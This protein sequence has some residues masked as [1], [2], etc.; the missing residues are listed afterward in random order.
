[1][2]RTAVVRGLGSWLPP[3]LVTNH[4]LAQ[5]LDTSDDWIRS[6]TGIGARHVITPGVATSDLAVQAG[7]RAL[8]SAAIKGVDAVVLATTTPDYLCPATAPLVSARLGLGNVPAFDVA[9]VCTGFLYA[10]ATAAGLI[11]S[12]VAD[13]VL[14][15]GADT[16][17][18]VLDPQDRSTRAIFG[19]GAGAV[20]LA[21][22]TADEIGALGPVRLASDGA[23]AKLIYIPSGGS[24]DPFRTPTA[25]QADPFFRM[26]GRAV[27]RQAVEHMTSSCIAALHDIGWTVDDVDLLVAHQANLRIM[28]AVTDRLGV[29]RCRCAVHLDRVGNTAAASI[30][31][32]LDNATRSGLLLPGHRVLMTAFGG[33][34]TWGACTMRWPDIEPG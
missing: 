22:G 16:F 5:Q 30:P 26:E 17:S 13:C 21:S 2:K 28:H 12:E 11:S 1:M 15:I 29:P 24:R 25:R 10:L 33:G 32:A 20:V 31:L 3:R 19:D 18:T 9:A 14:V 34:L 7:A 8:K 4:D 6:R 27:F 23:A